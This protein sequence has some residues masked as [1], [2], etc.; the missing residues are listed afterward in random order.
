M[1]WRAIG[2]SIQKK[3]GGK[4]RTVAHAKSPAAAKASVRA[5]YAAGHK[6]G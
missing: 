1:P 6:K 2:K 3:S 5:R 4:W